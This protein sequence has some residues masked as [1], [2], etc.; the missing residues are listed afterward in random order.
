M[1]KSLLIL[2]AGPYRSGTGDDPEKIAANHE[3]L[4]QAALAVW[5]RGHIP[6]IGEWIA[7][8]L[9][10]A[11]GSKQMGDAVWDQIVYPVADRLLEHCQA[12]YRIPGASRGADGDEA[13]AVERGIPVYT[14]LEQIP[15]GRP[16]EGRPR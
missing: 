3:R 2:V 1:E 10:K 14:D 11:A 12:V 6:V 4:T 16:R 7:L 8:P 13:L 5:D 9:A 15:V